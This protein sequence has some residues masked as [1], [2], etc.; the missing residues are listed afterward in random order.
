M[1]NVP[2]RHLSQLPLIRGSIGAE[3]EEGRSRRALFLSESERL[4]E[5][6]RFEPEY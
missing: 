4:S 3:D 6:V 2:R 1:I 5:K